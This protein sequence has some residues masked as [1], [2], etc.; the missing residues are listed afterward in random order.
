MWFSS[1]DWDIMGIASG[2]QTW[3]A[4]RSPNEMKVIAREIYPT[5]WWL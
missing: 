3:Q 2:N 5:E 4:G 1:F